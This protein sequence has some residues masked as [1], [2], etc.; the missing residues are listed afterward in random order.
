MKPIKR[1]PEKQ[2]YRCDN[3][4]A[5]LAPAG[6]VFAAGIIAL[7]WAVIARQPAVYLMALGFGLYGA[8]LFVRSR[9]RFRAVDPAHKTDNNV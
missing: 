5:T 4:I 7:V 3:A 2:G 9:A 6:M 8:L 1:A